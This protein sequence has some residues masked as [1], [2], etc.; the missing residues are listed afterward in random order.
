M[1]AKLSRAGGLSSRGAAT[2]LP[3]IPAWEG[4]QPSAFPLLLCSPTAH[5][6]SGGQCQ[7]LEGHGVPGLPHPLSGEER[8]VPACR[9]WSQASFSVM[10]HQYPRDISI[11]VTS[12]SMW[13]PEFS[14]WKF[15]PL[16]F[17][18]WPKEQS[19]V[20]SGQ[21]VS[22][23]RLLSTHM[24]SIRTNSHWESNFILKWLTHKFQDLEEVCYTNHFP[25]KLL[26]IL[27]VAL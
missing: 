20:C 2:K 4:Y 10:W 6:T 9:S 8:L 5:H 19:K 21:S 24:Q 13:Q 14:H 26:T 22:T 17:S 16:P 3:L 12:V 1:G 25:R 23:R 11:H 15:P 18:C 7:M 27:Q